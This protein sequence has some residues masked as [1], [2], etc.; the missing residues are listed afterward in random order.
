[1]GRKFIGAYDVSPKGA[2]GFGRELQG[3]HRVCKIAGHP[4][5]GGKPSIVVGQSSQFL[6]TVRDAS[7]EPVA[8]KP[9]SVASMA[10]LRTSSTAE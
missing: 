8:G 4:D 6:V 3:D 1:M 2:S 5:D 9:V 7:G 10:R